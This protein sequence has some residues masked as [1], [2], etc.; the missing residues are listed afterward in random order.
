MARYRFAGENERLNDVKNFCHGA[1][2][3]DI[4]VAHSLCDKIFLRL[5]VAFMDS[6]QILA[7]W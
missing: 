2:V 5:I 7:F 3:S 6:I 4:I 1:I